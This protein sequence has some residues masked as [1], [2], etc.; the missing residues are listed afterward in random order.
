MD[1]ND[2]NFGDDEP[3]AVPDAQGIVTGK[4]TG[5]GSGKTRFSW[6]DVRIAELVEAVSVHFH[7]AVNQVAKTTW[8][9]VCKTLLLSP[10]FKGVT[11]V[12]LTDQ[13][14]SRKWESV[15]KVWKIDNG[16]G[17][18]GQRANLSAKPSVVTAYDENMLAICKSTHNKFLL[19]EK[20]KAMITEQASALSDVT[21]IITGGGGKRGI[22]L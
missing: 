16:Y 10:Q 21:D 9:K 17:V 6:T 11:P 22:Y 12:E 5:K 1:F 8:P 3:I 18:N 14:C 13:M 15:S 19:T 7:P 2:P 20:Q 4:V